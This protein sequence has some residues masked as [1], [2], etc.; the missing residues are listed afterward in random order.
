MIGS[1]NRRLNSPFSG[2]EHTFSVPFL[3]F[4]YRKTQKH[5]MMMNTINM[6]IKLYKINIMQH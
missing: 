3:F 4:L 6:A 1:V 2:M 5:T